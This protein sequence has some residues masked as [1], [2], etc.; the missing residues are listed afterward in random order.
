MNIFMANMNIKQILVLAV[1]M[2]LLTSAMAQRPRDAYDNPR[3]RDIASMVGDLSTSQK[4]KLDAISSESKLRVGSLRA[5]QKAVRDSIAMFIQR[6]GDQSKKLYPLFEREAQL[7]CSISC[8]MYRT[9]LRIDEV[10]TPEQ[11]KQV[12]ETCRKNDRKMKNEK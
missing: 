3:D 4:K 5:Q 6:D 2:L 10:L 1:A 9:K 12:R 7:Q 11:R 8:E